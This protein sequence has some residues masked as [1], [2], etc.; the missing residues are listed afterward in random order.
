M[1]FHFA[2]KS[3]MRMFSC[4]PMLCASYLCLPTALVGA[5]TLDEMVAVW[6][7][8]EATCDDIHAKWKSVMVGPGHI[9][10]DT[11]H[12]LRGASADDARVSFENILKWRGHATERFNYWTNMP[13]RNAETGQI[14]EGDVTTVVKGDTEAKTMKFAK[15]RDFS[16][17]TLR[18]SSPGI[19]T[20]PTFR[21]LILTFRLLNQKMGGYDQSSF[22]LT[23]ETGVVHGHECQLVVLLDQTTGRRVHELLVDPA[24]EYSIRRYRLNYPNG[25]PWQQLDIEYT[26]DRKLGWIPRSWTTTTMD[27]AGERL[28]FVDE[29]LE[30][31]KVNIG[32]SDEEFS[33]DF[34]PQTLVTDMRQ[35]SRLYFLVQQD[36]SRREMSEEEKVRL[37]SGAMKQVFPSLSNQT[38]EGG[39]I[40]WYVLLAMMALLIA[41]VLVFVF[42]RPSRGRSKTV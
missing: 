7:K 6:A 18:A 27:E 21:P 13:G 22:R 39:T 9:Q 14:E 33:V 37:Y 1:I 17:G 23:E 28:E 5:A 3:L 42:K 30:F 4:M 31:L 20:F 10:L 11:N 38:R 40:T 15:N 34:G 25:A 32:L 24:A 19:A 29:E 8:R 12:E 16:E 26:Q 36:G 41:V 35:G 2:H